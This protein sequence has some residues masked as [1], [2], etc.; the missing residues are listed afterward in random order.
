MIF[1]LIR[2]GSIYILKKMIRASLLGIFKHINVKYSLFK[3]ESSPSHSGG[4]PGNIITVARL[5]LQSVAG[6]LPLVKQLKRTEVVLAS[7]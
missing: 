6:I 7:G 4:P 2:S 1:F 3:V 5:L